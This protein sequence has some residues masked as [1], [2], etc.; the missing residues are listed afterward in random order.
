MRKGEPLMKLI[1]WLSETICWMNDCFRR[2]R[3]KPVPAFWGPTG[4]LRA[5]KTNKLFYGAVIGASL[6]GFIISLSAENVAA[7]SANSRKTVAAGLGFQDADMSSITVKTY[8]AES[9]EVLSSETYELDIKEEGPAM[10][11]PSS[12]IF[13]GGV[14][15]GEDGLSEFIL[16][17]Y[18]AENGKFLWEGRLNLGVGIDPDVAAFPV[19]AYVQPRTAVLRVFNRTKKSGQPYFVLR[20][21]NPE[22]GQLVWGDQFSADA[23]NV[24]VERISR[25]VIDM[26]GGG[27][28]E[29]DFR[30]K[31]PDEA[32]RQVLWED[33][34]VPGVDE[35]V[36]GL[37]RS[38]DP[39]MLPVWPDSS[40]QIAGKDGI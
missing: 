34:V 25:S 17:V 11:Q 29:I 10:H 12:R 38:D 15:V 1:T 20:A 33:K 13:A 19:V 35:E 9:G 23:A 6:A 32:G 31:M 27:P 3:L 14:G 18:D 5:K 37:E 4:L 8:D 40:S 22:T 30:I 39:G 21:I 7:A 26:T 2:V 16:R 28:S 36:A 24:K